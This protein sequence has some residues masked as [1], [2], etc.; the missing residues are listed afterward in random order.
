MLTHPTLPYE[1]YLPCAAIQMKSDPQ[2]NFHS[3]REPQ[4]ASAPLRNPR[5]V[6]VHHGASNYNTLHI[7]IIA[8]AATPPSFGSKKRFQ[9]RALRFRDFTLLKVSYLNPYSTLYQDRLH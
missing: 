7:K 4:G 9:T 6:F 2:R 5:R 8:T 1:L 3:G